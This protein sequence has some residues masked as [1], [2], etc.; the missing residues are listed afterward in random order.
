MLFSQVRE[1]YNI[2]LQVLNNMI[3]PSCLLICSGGCTA[4]SILD[5]CSVVDVVDS[6][7]EQLLLC[8]L[9]MFVILFLDDYEDI[10]F[11]SISDKSRK[12][13]NSDY[14]CEKFVKYA[15]I[16]DRG[17]VIEFYKNFCFNMSESLCNVGMFEKVFRE[18][19]SNN[20]DYNLC[21]NRK[22]LSEVFG[23]NSV[24]FSINKEFTDH[25]KN[26]ISQYK[27]EENNNIVNYFWDSIKYGKYVNEFPRY[28][29]DG[30]L[31]V[32]GSHKLRCFNMDFFTYL[33]ISDS[34]DC[35][36]CSNILDWMDDDERLCLVK[37]ISKKL[38][39]GG[40]CIF[41]RLNG[42]YMLKN[43]CEKYFDEIFDCGVQ[44]VDKSLFY[45]EVYVGCVNK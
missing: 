20:Y 39:V 1:D 19:V 35:I 45:S 8:K 23:E 17:V 2:N 21:F 28:I 4:L 42:D 36:D 37:M 11:G 38:N 5:K 43:I 13:L 41:R 29:S 9:K 6:D 7:I 16:C 34:Y 33:S 32:N 30:H 27:I 18:L 26:V 14:Y 25:F 24:K 40:C 22:Y 10:L 44:F 15:M 12:L 31:V 3:N